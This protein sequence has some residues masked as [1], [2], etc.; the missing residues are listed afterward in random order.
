MRS[1]SR[2]SESSCLY[3]FREFTILVYGLRLIF[4]R[5]KRILGK[6][7]YFSIIPLFSYLL[8]MKKLL[9]FLVFLLP[10]SSFATPDY[11]SVE[12]EIFSFQKGFI[13]ELRNTLQITSSGVMQSGDMR[14]S[15]S[16]DVPY[17]GSGKVSL[18]ADRYSIT[19]DR[20][21][22]DS[23]IDYRGR[24]SFDVH[25]IDRSYHYTTDTYTTKPKEFSGY[26][27]FSLLLTQVGKD[28]YIK[29]GRLD[30]AL[31]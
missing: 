17:F 3:S 8:F 6:I 4:L 12:S 1:D 29:L 28:A 21:T 26:V 7:R 10:A 13:S 2:S 14:I 9:F 18:S 20:K 5:N 22:G 24:V 23:E 19:V 31:S 16:F 11:S 27:D 30:G 25:G 15:A